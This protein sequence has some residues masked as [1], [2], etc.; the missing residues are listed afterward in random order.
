MPNISA[1]LVD[2]LV[3]VSIG[4]FV[5]TGELVARYRDDPA[6]ALRSLPAML[7]VAL[8][9]GAAAAALALIQTFG[10]TFGADD[11][12]AAL[13]WTRVLVAG[14]GAMALFR[15]SLFT[16]RVGN[17]DVAVGPSSFLQVV[18]NAA[19]REVDRRRARARAKDVG[20]AMEGVTFDDA[21]QALPTYCF[22]LMQ[23]AS[24]ED[25]KALAKQVAVVQN[26]T[27]M[28]DR[29]K[30]LALG[31]ALMNLVGRSALEAAVVS[32]YGERVGSSSRRLPVAHRVLATTRPKGTT[33]GS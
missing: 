31:L 3:V 19:D 20:V 2:Y 32:L 27:A 15:S 26:A 13:R 8:N 21:V 23:N 25:Q 5:G 17:Q 4:G 33:T 1:D 30:C 10:W 24:D 16:V 7:Y 29:A 9:A 11:G 22:A 6:R 28:D 12:S 14:A 18:L